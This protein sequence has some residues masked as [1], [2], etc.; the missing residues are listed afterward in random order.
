MS[1]VVEGGVD[2][3]WGW[4]GP[5]TEDSTV[6]SGNSD[7]NSLVLE[8]LCSCLHLSSIYKSPVYGL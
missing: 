8:I 2:V 7:S 6:Q 3:G 1:T 4:S 5:V